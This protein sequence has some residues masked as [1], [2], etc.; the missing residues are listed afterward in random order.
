MSPERKQLFLSQLRDKR[1]ELKKR[2]L[3]HHS[4]NIVSSQEVDSRPP[5]KRA[6]PSISHTLSLDQGHASSATNILQDERAESKKRKLLHPSSNSLEVDSR[7]P[8]KCALRII[9]PSL[10]PEEG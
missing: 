3:L 6:L 1:A 2:K 10:S 8:K 7:P 4:S 5:K 9:N